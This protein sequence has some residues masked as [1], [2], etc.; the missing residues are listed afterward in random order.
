M[1]RMPDGLLKLGGL[2]GVFAAK[3]R[4]LVRSAS[5]L[6]L[7]VAPDGAEATDLLAGRALQ[8]AWLALAAE[9]LATQ[10]MMSLLVLENVA[11]RGDRGL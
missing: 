9:G 6:C 10:P 8:R 7:V 4:Q 11:D 5:G 2:A 1:K 3:A